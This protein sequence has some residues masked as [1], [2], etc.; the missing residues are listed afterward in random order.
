M[1]SIVSGFSRSSSAST[2]WPALATAKSMRPKRATVVGDDALDRG[3]IG[4]VGSED[5]RDRPGARAAQASRRLFQR[6]DVAADERDVGAATRKLDRDRAA[7]AAARAGDQARSFRRSSY[8][9]LSAAR[10][11]CAQLFDARRSRSRRQRRRRVRQ[12]L[13]QR[14]EHAARAELD[15]EIGSIREETLRGLVPAHLVDDRATRFASI[16]ATSR[17]GCASTLEITSNGGIAKL[18]RL[19]RRPRNAFDRRLHQIA[20]PRARDVER[21]DAFRA[22]VEQR[23]AARSARLRD[24]R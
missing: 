12:A 6:C 20:V 18:R 7:D 15:D 23:F 17:Y 3:L 4:D 16:V 14:A 8:A 5:V 11:R 9:R 21:H 2:D 19:R 24:R 1:W 13:H 10:E 22:G